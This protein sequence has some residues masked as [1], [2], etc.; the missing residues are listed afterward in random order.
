MTFL[1]IIAKILSVPLVIV[2]WLLKWAAIFFGSISGTIIWIVSGLLVALPSVSI[3]FGLMTF[4]EAIP[5][6]ITSFVC[7]LVP[8]I[9]AGLVG[10]I[11]A[12]CE[13]LHE[14]IWD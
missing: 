10:L 7:F 3:L 9:F 14:F 12:A 1:R 4:R 5:A 13:G 11:D 6:Y 2:L 8:V